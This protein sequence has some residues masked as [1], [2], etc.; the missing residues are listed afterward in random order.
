MIR[1]TEEAWGEYQTIFWLGYFEIRSNQG[2]GNCCQ[3]KPK[4]EADNLSYIV[5]KRIMTN[6]PSHE[7][8]TDIE[9]HA[10][11]AQPTK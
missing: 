4:V 7:K 9:N 6:T 5:L 8:Q 3:P 11:R 10:L 1:V 2:R